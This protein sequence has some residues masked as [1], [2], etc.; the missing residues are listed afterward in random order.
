MLFFG[1]ITKLEELLVVFVRFPILNGCLVDE[2][3]A[4][5]SDYRFANSLHKTPS[6]YY[7]QSNFK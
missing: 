7:S 2:A 3:G 5:A 1:M 4:E 6:F